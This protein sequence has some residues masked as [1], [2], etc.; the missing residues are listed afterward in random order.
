MDDPRL[1]EA[2]TLAPRDCTRIWSFFQDGGAENMRAL[3]G[4]MASLIG[5]PAPWRESA[6]VES[7]GYCLAARRTAGADARRALLV[8]YAPFFFGRPRANPRARRRLAARGMA[9][10]GPSSPA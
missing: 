6:R 10:E 5:I 4:L 1:R 2:S 7:A 8:F 9:V 3:L